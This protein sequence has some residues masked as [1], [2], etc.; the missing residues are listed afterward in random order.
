MG[1]TSSGWLK[2]ALLGLSGNRLFSGSVCRE[3]IGGRFGLSYSLDGCSMLVMG[4]ELLPAIFVDLLGSDG[5]AIIMQKK[6][7]H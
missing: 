5:S 7:M 2:C 3:C 1:G 4:A 6:K